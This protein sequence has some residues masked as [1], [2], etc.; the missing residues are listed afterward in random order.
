MTEVMSSAPSSD[1]EKDRKQQPIAAAEM[2]QQRP[3]ITTQSVDEPS[4]VAILMEHHGRFVAAA[5]RELPSKVLEDLMLFRWQLAYALTF[6]IF[7]PYMPPALAIIAWSIF[8]PV[9]VSELRSW[10]SAEWP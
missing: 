8:L 6:G 1:Q 10:S 9:F 7:A 5:R 2:P 4:N 3:H